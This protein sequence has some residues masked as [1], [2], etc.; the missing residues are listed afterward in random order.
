MTKRFTKYLAVPLIIGLVPFYAYANGSKDNN[1]IVNM[2]PLNDSGVW[3]SVGISIKGK[4]LNVTIEA[5]GLEVGKPHPQH[6]HGHDSSKT[7]ATCP[8]L[9][10]DVDGDGVVSVG[11]G[12]PSYG[13]IVLPLVP[14][15]LVDAAGNLSYTAT[16]PINPKSLRPIAKRTV[17]MHG[18]TVNG[19]YVP[20]LPIACGEI[21]KV[22]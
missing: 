12:L 3:A 8:G 6:I 7:N 4:T 2:L 13:P 15:D 14:F 22:N 21:E 11:E 19:N 9:E 1:Y 20:S 10:A 5:T 17:V 18:L 16:F